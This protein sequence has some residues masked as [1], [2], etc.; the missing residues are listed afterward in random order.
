MNAE[1]TDAELRLMR[2]AVRQYEDNLNIT[3]IGGREKTVLLIQKL[4]SLLPNNIK[5]Q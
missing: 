4:D 3:D 2:R 5:E 1:F